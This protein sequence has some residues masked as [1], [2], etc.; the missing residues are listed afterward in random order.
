MFRVSLIYGEDRKENIKKALNLLSDDI[1][2]SIKDKD[3]ILIKPNFVSTTV[4]LSATSKNAVMG[5]LEFLRENNLLEDRKIIIA[6]GAALG[7]TNDGFKNF[8]YYDLKKDFDIEFLDLNKT[9]S[10][11]I[12]IYDKNL[13]LIKINCAKIMIKD[14]NPNI[15]YISICPP[16]THDTVIVTLSIKNIIVGSL[17]ND[18]EKIHQNIKS[19]NLTLA[20]IYK[21]YIRP[22]LSIID[23]FIGMEG[24][25]PVDG[26]P[27]E[28]KIAMAGLNPLYVDSLMTYLMGIDPIEVGY[29]YYLGIKRDFLKDLEVLGEDFEKHKRKFKL[30]K[31]SDYQF[32]W[33]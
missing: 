16:K 1:K 10:Y 26:D 14:L 17:Q 31:T 3:V 6:E 22:D 21:E 18:K 25:G 27:V 9:N 30:H 23:G 13:N 32:K 8:G 28:M 2:R 11:K 12:D 29:L 5:L 4:Q 33:R 24:D 15:F 7:E 20:K 19:I